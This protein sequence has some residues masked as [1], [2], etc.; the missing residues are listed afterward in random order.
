MIKLLSKSK[1]KKQQYE[2]ATNPVPSY[3]FEIVTNFAFSTPTIIDAKMLYDDN[4]NTNRIFE[5]NTIQSLT[6]ERIE[7]GISYKTEY[8]I[9]MM[10]PDFNDVYKDEDT[11]KNYTW[12]YYMDKIFSNLHKIRSATH[13]SID[14]NL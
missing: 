6:F 12:I 14:M 7:N 13:T 5:E 1:K 9:D 8:V 10:F 4:N 3:I 11:F 2:L